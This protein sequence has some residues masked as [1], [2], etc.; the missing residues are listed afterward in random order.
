MIRVDTSSSTEVVAVD[1]LDGSGRVRLLCCY[2][3]QTGPAHIRRERVRA[4]C[5]DITNCASTDQTLIV[6]GDF[7]LPSID[8]T[9]LS[10]TDCTNMESMLTDCCYHNSLYQLIH[11]PTHRYGGILDLLLTT[12]PDLVDEV[13]LTSPP[14]PSDHLAIAFHMLAQSTLEHHTAPSYNYKEMDEFMIASHLDAIHW[15]TFFEN[16]DCVDSMFNEF[17]ECCTFL[18]RNSVPIARSSTNLE[19]LRSHVHAL[20]SQ[21]KEAVDAAKTAKKRR[22]HRCSV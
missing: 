3:P 2:N 16:Y 14:T 10:F 12:D 13:K 1:I 4:S 19:K 9:N 18:I 11:S 5:S 8:W 15:P 17:V 20:Q 21:T 22:S 7:N 6:L